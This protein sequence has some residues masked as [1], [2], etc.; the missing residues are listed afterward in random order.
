MET[1]GLFIIEP[2]AHEA[3]SVET[4]RSDS[5]HDATLMSVWCDTSAR[6]YYTLY[7]EIKRSGVYTIKLQLVKLTA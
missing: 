7:Q 3:A 5:G 1:R 2:K 4:L 6:I